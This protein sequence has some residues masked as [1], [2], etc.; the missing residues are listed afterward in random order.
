MPSEFLAPEAE[1]TLAFVA[2]PVVVL[3]DTLAAAFLAAA[4]LT[5]FTAADGLMIGSI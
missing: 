3:A 4:F 2:L 1:P 5:L